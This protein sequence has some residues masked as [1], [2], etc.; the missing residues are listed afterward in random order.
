MLKPVL[1]FVKGYRSNQ[2]YEVPMT[3]D[4]NLIGKCPV[5]RAEILEAMSFQIGRASCRERV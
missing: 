2:L 5:N 3:D 4:D 1:F